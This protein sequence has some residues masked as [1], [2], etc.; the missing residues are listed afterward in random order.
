MRAMLIADMRNQKRKIKAMFGAATKKRRN[1]TCRVCLLVKF[2]KAKRE[3][4]EYREREYSD[5]Y[6]NI[7]REI[8]KAWRL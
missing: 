1:A 7:K 5:V 8:R 4:R 6:L 2:R 3:S